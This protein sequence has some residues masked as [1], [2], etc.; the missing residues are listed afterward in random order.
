MATRIKTGPKVLLAGLLIFAFVLGLREMAAYGILPTPGF[1]KSIVPVVRVVPDVKDAQ[2]S[3]VAPA[4]LPTDRLASVAAPF[5]RGEVWEWNAQASIMLA[6]GGAQTTKG[7]LME[8]HG[9]NLLLARQDDTTQMQGD[10]AKCAK[11]IQDGALQCTTG[12]NF[13]IIMGDGAGQFISGLNA[14]LKAAGVTGPESAPKIYAATGYSRGEDSF[15]V[16]PVVKTNPQ[17]ARGILVAGVIRDGDWN[18]AEKWASDNSIPSNPDEH[19]YDPDAIN[20][21]NAPDYLKAAEMYNAGF[22]ETRQ[23]AKNGKLT[24]AMKNVCVNAV[25]T[26][27]PGDVNI[28][29]GK[30]GLIKLV[31]SKQ[32]RSQ[33]PAVILGPALFFQRNRAE[34]EGMLAATFEAGD[35]IKAFDQALHK[36]AD[37][38]ASVY[39]DAAANGAYWYK[40]YKGVTETD[41]QGLRVD[42]G[43]ST[44][45]NLADNLTLFGLAQGSNDNMRATYTVFRDVDLQQYPDM[46]KGTPIPEAKD[47][48]DK[49]FI[50][51]AQAKME[52]PGAVEDEPTYSADSGDVVS[53]RAYMINFEVNEA[54]FTSAGEATMRD[55]RDSLAITGLFITVD[56]YTDNT[57]AP[58]RNRELSQERAEAVKDWLQ[59]AAATNFPDKRFKVAGHGSDNPVASN[60]TAVGKAQNR[61]VEI[62][63]SEN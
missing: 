56:G 16:L 25:V 44:V 22:C 37:I 17:A 10:L 42:L 46:F 9:A 54:T 20:W 29:H 26:W 23:V 41:S 60:D 51:G 40:Y 62:T 45:S 39:N 63:L 49:S 14:A 3:N 47:V 27:T 8:K 43:G 18:I 5:A 58:G 7:S 61:R 35:Q 19:T 52:S 12:A 57:G 15:E 48:E 30:G 50:T 38:E 34:M 13:V 24:G 32:Y 6:N 2:V 4:A 28:A 1:M 33:M 31:S 59:K 21:V 36:A 53:K 11:E 55:L